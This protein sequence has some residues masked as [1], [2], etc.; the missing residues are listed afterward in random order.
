MVQVKQ[1]Y[2]EDNDTAPGET[3]GKKEYAVALHSAKQQDNQ[4]WHLVAIYHNKNALESSPCHYKK[5]KDDKHFQ[6]ID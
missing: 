3:H 5:G 2:Y 4:A 6:I 1:L